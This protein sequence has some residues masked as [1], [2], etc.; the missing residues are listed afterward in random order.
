[1]DSSSIRKTD[2]II[3]KSVDVDCDAAIDSQL[4]K[5]PKTLLVEIQQHQVRQRSHLTH[6]HTKVP[7]SLLSEIKDY[8]NRE[9]QRGRQNEILDIVCGI[10][11]VAAAGGDQCQE[12]VK[13]NCSFLSPMKK[14]RTLDVDKSK[15]CMLSL[16]SDS[17]EECED[18]E[19]EKAS[20]ATSS[21]ATSSSSTTQD[22]PRKVHFNPLTSI[23]FTISREEITEEEKKEYWLQ[24]QEFALIRMRD[25]YLGNLVEQK[26]RE[27]DAGFATDTYALTPSSIAIS[28]Q[29]WI[30]TRGLEYK[31]KRGFLRT[32]DRRLRCLE[33]VLVEQERQWDEHWDDGRNESPF[34]YDFGALAAVSIDISFECKIHARNVAA[35]DRR[36]VE[37]LLQAEE[38]Q[39]ESKE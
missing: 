13:N 35:N 24:D 31:M 2:R 39:E 28:P 32:K 9:Q 20:V 19:S 21:T 25:G 1:M 37:E 16:D 10:L 30:C 38:A 18:D 14:S 22:T 26:Q 23:Q 17:D 3:G 27:M 29:H 5:L 15:L 7:F 4:S 36:E 12:E 33:Q 6:I 8:R 34:Y 11:Q